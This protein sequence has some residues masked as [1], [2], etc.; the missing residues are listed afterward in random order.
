[1]PQHV[2]GPAQQPPVN[3]SSAPH[4]WLPIFVYVESHS[5]THSCPKEPL[6]VVG[7]LGMVRPVVHP[8]ATQLPPANTK[9]L[10]QRW[11][12]AGV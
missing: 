2:P 6:Q 11:F 12:P 4:T 3:A 10:W 8:F 9:V 1:M 7:E 5:N